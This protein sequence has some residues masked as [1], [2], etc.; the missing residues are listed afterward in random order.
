MGMVMSYMGGTGVE[1]A[2]K[3]MTMTTG[4]LYD[5]VIEK[6]KIENFEDFHVAILDIFN[7]INTSLPGKHYDAPALDDVQKFYEKWNESDGDK[8]ER[9]TDYMNEKVNLSKADESMMIT[10]ILAPPL[11]LVAKKTGQSLPQLGVM[12]AI[13]DVAFVPGATILALIATKLT[14][15]MAFK[16]L[17]S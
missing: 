1:F 15:R 16:N 10:G 17:P 13:P 7:A 6:K 3:A 12:K 11:A 9:F 8:K 4:T 14:K 5:R 2:S